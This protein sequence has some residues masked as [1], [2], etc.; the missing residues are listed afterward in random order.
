MIL[1]TLGTCTGKRLSPDS[2]FHEVYSHSIIYWN[3]VF[4]IQFIHLKPGNVALKKKKKKTGTLLEK[5]LDPMGLGQNILWHRLCLELIHNNVAVSHL[6]FLALMKAPDYYIK[7]VLVF[8]KTLSFN[9]LI[10]FSLEPKSYRAM[11]HPP[12]KCWHTLWGPVT[13]ICACVFIMSRP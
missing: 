5:I 2:A 1:H 12:L 8:I 9:S 13:G 6:V 11:T 4:F 3:N 10:L 7:S